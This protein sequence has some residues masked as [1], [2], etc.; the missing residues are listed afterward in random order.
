MLEKTNHRQ[1]TQARSS[2]LDKL[3][4]PNKNFSVFSL[5]L[6]LME[7][8]RISVKKKRKTNKTDRERLSWEAC[9]D[10][11]EEAARV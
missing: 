9:L 8:N 10:N 7:I 4:Y 1:W 3:C 11:T 5:S 2:T 6:Y